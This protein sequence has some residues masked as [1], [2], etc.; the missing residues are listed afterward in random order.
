MQILDNLKKKLLER[1]EQKCDEL[2][3]SIEDKIIR[4]TNQAIAFTSNTE[5][6]LTNISKNKDSKAIRYNIDVIGHQIAFLEFGS[7]V[8]N[9]SYIS[10]LKTD[11]IPDIVNFGKVPQR[12]LYGNQKGQQ[13]IWVFPYKTNVSTANGDQVYEYRVY[14]RKR[15]GGTSIY[16]LKYPVIATKGIPPQRMIYR[17]IQEAIQEKGVGNR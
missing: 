6:Y 11:Y 14:H 12:G 3:R 15:D 1:V 5:T 8:R 4:N 17:A 2:A 16:P 13:Q 10:R 7:G 9:E